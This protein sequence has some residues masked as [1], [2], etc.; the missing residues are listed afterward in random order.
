MLM[1]EHHSAQISKITNDG[2]T[3]SGTG[4][5]IGCSTHMATVGVKG[6]VNRPS[7]YRRESIILSFSGYSD[8]SES[9]QMTDFDETD[10]EPMVM[11]LYRR[12]R[13][14]YQQL[15]GYVRRRLTA[16]YRNH[17]INPRG[18]IPAHLLGM[19]FSI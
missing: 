10:I 7:C 15:H 18:P 11:R 6:F 12:I 13:P 4:C 9:W 2:L 14:L 17:G 5:F 16:V 8:V 19:R 3:R 1:A